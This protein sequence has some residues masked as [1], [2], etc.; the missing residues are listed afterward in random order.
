M[1]FGNGELAALL[2]V[3]AGGD[4]RLQI[5]NSDGWAGAELRYKLCTLRIRITPNPIAETGAQFE[6]SL[7]LQNGSIALTL[8]HA[9]LRVWADASDIRHPIVIEGTHRTGGTFDR[10]EAYM[11]TWRGNAT[12]NFLSD[13][14][15]AES[16]ASL[17][18]VVLATRISASDFAAEMDQNGLSAAVDVIKDPVVNRTFG[19]ILTLRGGNATRINSSGVSTRGAASFVLTATALTQQPA[20][21]VAS[22]AQ[23]LV[24]RE[25]AAAAIPLEV[26][27]A[28][29]SAYWNGVWNRS[30]V[31]VS[32]DV[33][34]T[35][36]GAVSTQYF[37]QRW[38][39]MIQGR[40]KFPIKF[41]GMSFGAHENKGIGHAYWWQNT[42]RL[43]IS[44]CC[45]LS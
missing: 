1:P 44:N 41:Q 18:S 12:D 35:A 40:G 6:Q 21:S 22:W 45:H 26:R 34:K 9:Q 23:A 3:E 16:G 8:G 37:L 27:A 11:N 29:H 25:R 15:L 17:T 36:V 42:V 20:P 14:E 33:N 32:S 39:E 31:Q 19:T 5:A 7:Q 2:W 4:I 24:A 38:I 28:R 10:I 43:P 30:W 13:T